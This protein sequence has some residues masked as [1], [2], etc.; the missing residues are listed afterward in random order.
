MVEAIEQRVQFVVDHS[1]Y[2][3]SETERDAIEETE[4]ELVKVESAQ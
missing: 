2:M 1:Q 3:V 4:L